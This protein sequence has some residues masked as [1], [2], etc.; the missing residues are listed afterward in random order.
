MMEW[1]YSHVHDLTV[2]E[3]PTIAM[4]QFA[5]WNTCL[6]CFSAPDKHSYSVSQFNRVNKLSTS[7]RLLQVHTFQ[8]YDIAE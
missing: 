6:V 3:L 5:G 7:S 4:Q 8:L 2:F 1:W